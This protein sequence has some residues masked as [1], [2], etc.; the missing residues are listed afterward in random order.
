MAKLVDKAFWEFRKT[1]TYGGMALATDR[2]FALLAKSRLE[3]EKT[4]F[5]H[6]ETWMGHVFIARESIK[7]A[8]IA[9]L[10]AG[11]GGTAECVLLP[12]GEFAEDDVRAML[13][14]L[15]EAPSLGK[16]VSGAWTGRQAVLSGER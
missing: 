5:V 6:L 16:A 1:L 10:K 15:E 8:V 7:R 9:E 11:L 13:A 14:A 3:L 12:G 4:S 2:G